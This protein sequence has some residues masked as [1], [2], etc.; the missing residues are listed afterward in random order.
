ME[1]GTFCRRRQRQ[2]VQQVE[3]KPSVWSALASR[4]PV[5]VD[6]RVGT[7]CTS[8]ADQMGN[9]FP[10]STPVCNGL[11]ETRVNRVSAASSLTY[12]LARIQ[13][14]CHTLV[15]PE[16]V[17]LINLGCS[18]HIDYIVIYADH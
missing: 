12:L 15:H 6:V 8:C 7:G 16:I 17:D 2:L 18:L 13:T 14:Q 9:L 3:V 5:A 11:S 4:Q 1:K 10:W